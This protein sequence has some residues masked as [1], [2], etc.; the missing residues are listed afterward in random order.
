MYLLV[1]KGVIIIYQRMLQESK[2]LEAK[3][4]DIERQIQLLPEGKLICAQYGNNSKWFHSD[5]HK[6]QYIKKKDKQLAEQLAYKKYLTSLLEDLSNEHR[7][8][9]FYLRH[10]QK[11]IPKSQQLLETSQEYKK[12][13]SSYFIPMKEE[14][15]QWTQELYE[16]NPY[17]PERANQRTSA[18]VYV[19]SKSE[20]LIAT[21]LHMN[22]IPFRYECALSLGGMTYYPDFTI[23]HPKTGEVYYWEHFGMMDS[24]DYVKK[25]CEKIHTY[26]I[27]GIVPSIRL[28]TT[29]ETQECPLSTEMIEREIAY[30]FG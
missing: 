7:A 19:R 26:T 8:I 22:Q 3:I 17:H 15:Y 14:L 20:V 30:Y 28:I 25:T 2:R 9:S 18:G 6:K 16:K 12:L 13:I 24:P 1:K 21:Y 5:G 27:H 23:R 4:R 29:Y 11:E 10:H